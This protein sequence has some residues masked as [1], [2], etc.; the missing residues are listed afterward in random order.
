MFVRSRKQIIAFVNRC[1]LGQTG[2]DEQLELADYDIDE[3]F[4]FWT[5]YGIGSA[6]ITGAISKETAR[7][8]QNRVGGLFRGMAVQIYL[9]RKCRRE[10]LERFRKYGLVVSKAD[11]HLKNREAVEFLFALADAFSAMVGESV[12][13]EMFR[14]AMGEEDFKRDCI[15]TLIFNADYFTEKFGGAIHY[16]SYVPLLE[17]FF[18]GCVDDG[19]AELFN[20]F[21]DEAEDVYLNVEKQDDLRQFGENTKVMYGITKFR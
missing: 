7:Q 16:E 19:S 4:Y 5:M 15:N 11:R 2:K 8:E 9:W 1:L 12:H 13:A 3:T 21:G 10:Q 18:A 14:K 6:Q 20:G 17:K